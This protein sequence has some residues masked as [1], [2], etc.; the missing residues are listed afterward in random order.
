[1]LTKKM[2]NRDIRK[3]L[4]G[5]ISAN[6]ISLEM[7]RSIATRRSQQIIHN[8]PPLKYK[9]MKTCSLIKALGKSR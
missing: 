1:M 8:L 2:E 9:K 3:A 5:N 7:P 4:T 6:E